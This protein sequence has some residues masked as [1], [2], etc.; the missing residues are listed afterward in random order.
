MIAAMMK[1]LLSAA[2]IAALLAPSAALACKGKDGIVK[3]SIKEGAEL[4]KNDGV[5][6]VDANGE[7]T[8]AKHGVIEGALLLTSSTEFALTELPSK[9]K[10]L[11]F[12][13]ANE[14]C[15]ASTMAAKKAKAAGYYNVAVLTEGIMGWK[16]AGLPI[17][18]ASKSTET[19]KAA[20]SSS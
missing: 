4:A 12:Y 15:S 3:L 6:F 9:D 11:V 10:K 13:C 19:Q 20:G 8:R 1:T 18:V 5:V 17:N 14:H 7:Q 2:V 16:T